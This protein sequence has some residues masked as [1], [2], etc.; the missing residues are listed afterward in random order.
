MKIYAGNLPF[1]MTEADLRQVFEAHGDVDSAIIITDRVTGRS[2][3]FGFVEMPD[4]DAAMKAIDALADYE[5]DGRKLVINK[6]KP[7]EDRGRRGGGGGRGGN[8]Y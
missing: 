8:R 4:D 5:S 1:S 2:R 3:G 7:R 6:A